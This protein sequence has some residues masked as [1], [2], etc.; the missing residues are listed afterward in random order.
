MKRKLPILIILLTFSSA[1]FAVDHFIME[2]ESGVTWLHNEAF[3]PEGS[4]HKDPD[5]ILYRVGPAFPI[6]FNES[7]FIRPSLTVISKSW[8]YVPENNWAMPVDSMWQDFMVMSLLL[9]VPVGYEIRFESF[10]LGF[11]GGPAFNFRIPLWGEG[12][13][14]RD[15]MVSYFYKSARFINL[16]VGFYFNIPLSEMISL[17]LKGDSWIPIH[18]MWSGTGLPFSDGLMVTASAGV[19]FTF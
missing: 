3:G 16:T 13:S 4:G 12:E 19:R 18:N 1:L 7:L 9:D 15:D 10:S 17:T 6:Y 8:Q 5:P 2:V 11:F 14:V